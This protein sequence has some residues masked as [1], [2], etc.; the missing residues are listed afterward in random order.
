MPVLILL[1]VPF[2]LGPP[3]FHGDSRLASCEPACVA[4][5]QEVGTALAA[6]AALP[7]EPDAREIMRQATARYEASRKAANS[8]TFIEREEEREM[9]DKGKVKSVESH[10][11]DV[12]RLEGQPYRRLIAKNDK[13][14]S[15]AEEKKEQERLDKSLK[16]DEQ[17]RAKRRERAAKGREERRKFFQ[18]IQDAYDFRRLADDTLDGRPMYV[19]EGTPRA[20]FQP[21]SREASIL[22]KLHGK[23]W[24]DKQELA[25]VK[26]EI[27]VTDTISFGLFLV[28]VN[29]GTH[30][31]FVATRVNDEVWLPK[32]SSMQGSARLA[33]FKKYNGLVETTWR[34]YKKFQTETKIVTTGEVK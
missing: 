32:S 6:A 17:D 11:W 33:V 30:M 7:G 12:T 4:P 2:Q 29:K 27:E 5:A 24:I 8:Y 19:L 1:L 22:P 31:N 18:E 20:G 13:P 3:V 26:A 15:P 16:E 14:L 10:T 28:R 25:W 23:L 21:K 9:D 34:D